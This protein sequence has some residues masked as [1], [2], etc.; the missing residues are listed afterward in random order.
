VDERRVE[1]LRVRFRKLGCDAQLAEARSLLF[2]SLLIGNY[3]IDA[4]HGRMSR[5]RVLKVAL[6]QLLRPPS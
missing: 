3:F 5:A 4:S 6:E 2:Y 1:F